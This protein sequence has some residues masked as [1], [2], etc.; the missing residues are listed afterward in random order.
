MNCAV[1][2]DF[3]VAAYSE[4]DMRN[5]QAGADLSVRMNVRVCHHRK[6]LVYESQSQTN[7]HPKPSRL[8]TANHFLKSM[9]HERP[10]SLRS[11]AAVSLLPATCQIG[12]KRPPLAVTCPTL[13]CICVVLQWISCPH[14]RNRANASLDPYENG[15]TYIHFCRPR[16]RG[17]S[18]PR[19]MK[20]RADPIPFGPYKLN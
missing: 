11:P 15:P 19:T 10:K 6:Q 2:S 18:T 3:G 13:N 12:S 7:G 5:E 20:T 8:G 9:D 1:G 16:I 17:A 14:R 4:A